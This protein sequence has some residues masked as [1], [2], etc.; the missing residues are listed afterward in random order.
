[1]FIEALAISTPTYE[2]YVW[3]TDKKNEYGPKSQEAGCYYFIEETETQTKI[4]I[5]CGC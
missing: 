1:M 3:Y 5:E 2:P 4:R